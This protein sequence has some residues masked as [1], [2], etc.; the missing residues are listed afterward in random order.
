MAF[1]IDFSLFFLVSISIL[2]FFS[3]IVYT[4]ATKLFRKSVIDQHYRMSKQ[5]QKGWSTLLR[6]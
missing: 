3:P 2:A 4:V 5:T 1:W 6:R